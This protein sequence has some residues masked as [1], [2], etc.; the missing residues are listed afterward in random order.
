MI[1][2]IRR[3][4]H[5][6]SRTWDNLAEGWRELWQRSRNSITRFMPATAEQAAPSRGEFPTWAVLAG[7][8]ADTGRH[9]VVRVE[10]PGIDRDDCEVNL[11]RDRLQ[12]SGEKRTDHELVDADYYVR[13]R[14]YGR[15]SRSIELP[16]AVDP[17]RAHAS[18]RSGVLTV[19]A[20]K[21]EA[22]SRRRLT[23]V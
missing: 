17:E 20:P 2:T 13:E 22:G 14:A 15:F 1:K 16:V 3:A 9:L 8:I 19:K 18:F 12:I 6:L 4:G 7:E 10:L 23:V 5:E 21:L 11:A